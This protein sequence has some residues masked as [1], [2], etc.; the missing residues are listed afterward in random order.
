V[1]LV[2]GEQ[3]RAV[4]PRGGQVLAEV[5]AGA[6]LVAL[7]ADSKLGLYLL[8]DAGTLTSYELSSHFAVVGG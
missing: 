2:P 3:V 4:E 7:Q 5:R 8:D 6:G 1:V